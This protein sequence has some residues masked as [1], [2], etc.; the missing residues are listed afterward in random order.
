MTSATRHP[1]IKPARAR[2]AAFTLIEVVI[3]TII[4]SL[5]MGAMVSTMLMAQRAMDTSSAGNQSVTTANQV[6]SQITNELSVAVSITE[7]TATAVT[8]T[9]PDRD[10]D[11]QAETIRYAW[12]GTAGDPLTRQYNG[13]AVVTIAENVHYFNMDYLTRTV[14]P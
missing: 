11:S 2:A 8:F 4:V 12:S 10:G 13:G 3:S 7:Q 9:V 14:G 5:I 1:G 6:V